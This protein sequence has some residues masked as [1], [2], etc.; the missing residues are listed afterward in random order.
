MIARVRGQMGAHRHPV[1]MLGALQERPGHWGDSGGIMRKWEKG[2]IFWEQVCLR[3]PQQLGSE[4][5]EGTRGPQRVS[6]RPLTS[7][8]K[9]GSQMSHCALAKLQRTH[10]SPTRTTSE[11]AYRTK[12][13]LVEFLVCNWKGMEIPTSQLARSSASV[14]P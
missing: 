4:A 7:C 13:V 2:K 6:W 12:N 14:S 11:T 5:E 3:D 1:A 10:T 9:I 8:L